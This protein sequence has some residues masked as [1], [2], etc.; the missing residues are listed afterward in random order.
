[1]GE[2]IAKL[3]ERIKHHATYVDVHNLK[4]WALGAALT[5]VA[6]LATVLIALLQ[7]VAGLIQTILT[8]LPRP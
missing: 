3:E 6:V 7:S 4:F 8:V 5:F 2:R 1:M